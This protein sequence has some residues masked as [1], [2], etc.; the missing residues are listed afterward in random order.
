MHNQWRG[1]VC[2]FVV[3]FFK[4]RLV[5]WDGEALRTPVTGHAQTLGAI[6]SGQLSYT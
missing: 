6:T 1:S 3:W 5:S 4:I 2:E